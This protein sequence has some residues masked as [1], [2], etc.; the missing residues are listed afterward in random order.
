MKCKTCRY[1]ILHNYAKDIYQFFFYKF[2]IEIM[3][4][5]HCEKTMK[6]NLQIPTQINKFI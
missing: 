1:F 4:N 2:C 3:K 6:Y 5:V